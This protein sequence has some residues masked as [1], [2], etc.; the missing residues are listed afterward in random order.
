[1]VAR[2]PEANG[3][4]HQ[5]EYRRQ[6]NE[7]GEAGGEYGPPASQERG[8]CLPVRLK[9]FSAILGAWHESKL[10]IE[11]VQKDIRKVSSVFSRQLGR[12]FQHCNQVIV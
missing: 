10:R 3:E 2:M 12:C 6:Q 1:M 7:Q 4:T 9:C 8:D 11:L 5:P